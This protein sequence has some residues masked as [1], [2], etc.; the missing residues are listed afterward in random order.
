[1]RI[2]KTNIAA[3]LITASIAGSGEMPLM[4]SGIAHAF[5]PSKVIQDE[6][7]LKEISQFIFDARKE[8]KEAEA[9]GV[10]KFAA[11]S[12]NS[13]AQWK[14]GNMYEIGDGLKR[15][16][17]A[18]FKIFI[19]IIER[20]S[21]ANPVS[22]E[23]Q[24]ASNAMVAL[25]RYYDKGIPAGNIAPDPLQA[26]KMFT[27]AA[28]IFHN[29]SGQFE[30]AR[31]N[32]DKSDGMHDPKLAARMLTLAYNKGHIGAKALLGSMIF[33]GNQVTADPVKGLVMMGEAKLAASP[34]DY[35]WIAELQEEAFAMATSDQRRASIEQIAK[36]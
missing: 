4:Q 30:L 5:D 21:F 8:G 15:D 25:G 36:Q 27:T 6:I 34:L 17:L 13:A 3:I 32:L 19:G 2:S 10:L 24:A 7:S 14:L 11:D 23:G 9:I 12:G 22:P 31:M 26:R 29:A 35:D 18:A 33:D 28:W 20:L 1:M 16:P